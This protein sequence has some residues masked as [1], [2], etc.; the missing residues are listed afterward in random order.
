MG[1]TRGGWEVRAAMAEAAD[2]VVKGAEGKEHG[3]RPTP[4]SARGDEG[5]GGGSMHVRWGGGRACAGGG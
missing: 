5:N 2:A 1:V 3:L 4:V